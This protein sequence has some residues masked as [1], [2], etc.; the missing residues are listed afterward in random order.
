MRRTL[1]SYPKWWTWVAIG[2]PLF[3]AFRAAGL[4][5][6]A[7]G[8]QFFLAFVQWFVLLQFGY[9][10]VWLARKLLHVLRGPLEAAIFGTRSWARGEVLDAPAPEMTQ[11][12][13]SEARTESPASNSAT[14]SAES[15][16]WNAPADPQAAARA[17]AAETPDP[18]ERGQPLHL[19]Q[20]TTP[21][22]KAVRLEPA[23]AA[24]FCGRCG[25]RRVDAE[26][27]FC[28]SCGVSL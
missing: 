13:A 11:I 27:L 2:V 15:V 21:A 7:A 26:D 14:V 8:L 1:T 5:R 6:D 12:A 20:W 23:V 19:T 18:D 25:A 17:S 10:L 3:M 28:R 9:G 16:G 24:R 4:A 22:E